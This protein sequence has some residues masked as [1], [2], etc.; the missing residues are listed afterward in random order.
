M[1]YS[2]KLYAI[3][4]CQAVKEAKTADSINK[5]IKSLLVLV[6]KNRDQKK[7]R[8]IAFFAEKI[9]NKESGHRKILVESARVLTKENEEMIDSFTKKTDQVVKKINPSLVA[10]VKIV[11][12][13]EVQIDGSFSKKIKRVLNTI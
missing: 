5:C 10:G 3:A 7:L 6:E 2:P 12:D 13:D 1:N 4:F 11:I 8:D 9:L